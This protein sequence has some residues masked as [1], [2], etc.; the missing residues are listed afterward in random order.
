MFNFR[1]LSVVPVVLSASL[2]IASSSQVAN[3]PTSAEAIAAIQAYGQR[4]LTEQ[5]AP[6]MSVTIT[7]RTHTISVLTYGYSNA[8]AKTPVTPQTR[9]IVY[10]ITKSFVALA[11]LRQHDAGRLDLEA[12]VQRYLPWFS[13][14]SDG[15]PILVHQLLSHTS[16]LPTGY[17]PGWGTFGVAELRRTHVLFVPGTSW[18]YANAGYNTLADV[19]ASVMHV[20]WQD[21]VTTG[22]IDPL[23][24]SHT[25]PYLTP[26]S[27][28][29]VAYGYTFRDYDKAMPPTNIPLLVSTFNGTY[30]DPAG[31]VV[32]SPE[33]M[34]RYMRFYLNG[35][36]TES[37]QQLLR[38]ATFA[39]MTS[40]DHY[41]DGKPTGATTEELPEWPKFYSKYGLGLGVQSTA[42]DQ[43]IGHTGGGTGYTACMQMNLTRG[44]GV[45]AMS[46]LSEQPLHPCA[47]VRYAMAVLRSQSVG[48][49]LP[50]QPSPPPD[51]A[52]VTNAG[53]YAGTFADASS[54]LVIE[55][56]GQH[57]SLVDGG[58]TYQMLLSDTDTFWTD[59]PRL[60]TFYLTFDRNAAKVVVD[61]SYGPDFYFGSRYSGPRTFP[62]PAGYDRLIGRYEGSGGLA[63]FYF[64][65]GKLTMNGT[66]LKPRGG[67]AFTAGNTAIRFDTLA[68]GHMQRV[69]IDD[70]DSYRVDLP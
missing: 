46:N 13:T 12:P 64:V 29:D 67:S 38:P 60:Q 47:I 1:V 50:P 35:G 40:P 42:T 28:G 52:V 70:A 20:P 68:D 10:S 17:G 26:T 4:A 41:N 57:L 16:G 45:I 18:S 5:G 51:P 37:G 22:V 39:R 30:I 48:E 49:A 34:A 44:F 19:L 33:D 58:K 21:A 32:S 66:P 8:E 11:L 9:F 14:N 24:M 27:S 23:G 69:W 56:K 15:K 61:V 6:G 36:K 65:K 31:S 53:D 55:A 2:L 63:R 7:D 25:A 54:S 59:D 3:A 43:L 62:H